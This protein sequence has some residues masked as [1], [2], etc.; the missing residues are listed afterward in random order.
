MTPNGT[1]A[2]LERL[3]LNP[4]V[5]WSLGRSGAIAE[6]SRDED[7]SMVLDGLSIATSRGALRIV[8]DHPSARLFAGEALGHAETGWS[9]WL[10]L[11]L[12][13]AECTLQGRGTIAE[14]G[15]DRAALQA[16]SR[17]ALL[18]DLGLGG[19]YFQLG[20]RTDSNAVIAGLRAAL[21]RPL[22]AEAALVRSLMSTSPARVFESRLAR[23]EVAQAIAPVNGRSPEGPHTHILP[24]L[25]REDGAEPREAP[26]GW[27]AQ[28]VAY[29][30]HPLRDVHGRSKPFEAGAYQAF[31]ALLDTFG[32][33]DHCSVKRAVADAVRSGVSPQAFT[34]HPERC[35]SVRIALRQLRCLEGESAGLARWREAYGDS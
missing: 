30:P 22:L 15:P 24:H 14:I 5:A 13:K 27:V 18:F 11:C 16:A 28:I 26:S 25:L 2:A 7:E 6:F 20:V 21:G 17:H 35:D 31:Q 10:S 1:V 32:D 33:P 12:P 34:A 8:S 9:Q 3:L 19:P 4:Q 29:P 23:I